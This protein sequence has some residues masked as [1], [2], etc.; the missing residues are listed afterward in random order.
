LA[1]APFAPPAL[2]SKP[3]VPRPALG[4]ALVWTAVVLWSLNAV[5]AK[6]ILDSAGLSSMRL[7][8]VRATGAALILVAAVAV[9]RADTLRASRRELGFLAVFGI[10]GLAFVQL[11]YFVGIQRLDIGIAL[12]INYLAPVFVAL[13]A[14]FY[15]HD[16]V[17]RRLWLAIALC[18]LGLSLVVELWSGGSSLDGVGVLACL[19]TALAYAAYVLMAE[20]SLQGGRDVYSLLAWGFSFAAL[21]WAIVQPWWAFPVEVVDGSASLLGRFEDVELPV[22]LL[23]GYVVVL[24]TVVPFICLVS[25]LHH[26]PATR[27]TIVAMLEPVLAAVV[28]WI[29]LGEELAAVQILGGLVV[30]VGVV[31]AQTARADARDES[32]EDPRKMQK[33]VSS[34]RDLA[35][36]SS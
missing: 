29:W 5:I 21:F 32:H 24:G 18:L 7:A 3:P 23:L 4:Y 8:Q 1:D 19:V 11:F 31:L 9:W 14:R 6:I 15:E 28:A 22:W 30:L 25:A 26:V 33:D 16:P 10:L 17:R 35:R 27:V 36:G 34:S 12:V 13:W 2:E 20:R